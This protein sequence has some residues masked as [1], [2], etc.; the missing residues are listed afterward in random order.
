MVIPCSAT[1]NTL[2]PGSKFHTKSYY[3][4]GSSPL[5]EPA[6]GPIRD[7]ARMIGRALPHRAFTQCDR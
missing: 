2:P 5:A 7:P 6:D 1:W 4:I 3:R